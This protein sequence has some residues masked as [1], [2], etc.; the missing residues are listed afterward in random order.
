MAPIPMSPIEGCSSM[1]ESGVTSGRTMF[2]TR[3][4]GEHHVEIENQCT[5]S[6]EANYRF[7]KGDIKHV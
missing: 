7:S 4:R 6:Y 3:D 2:C 5:P 1:G